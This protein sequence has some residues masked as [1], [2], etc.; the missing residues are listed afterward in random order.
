MNMYKITSTILGGFALAAI[1]GCSS[2][3]TVETKEQ[4]IVMEKSTT[5]QGAAVSFTHNYDGRSEPGFVED[6]Q[7]FIQDEYDSGTLNISMTASEGLNLSS[8]G[9]TSFSMD[10]DAA[11]TINVSVSAQTPGKYYVNLQAKADA[12]NGQAMMR[13]YGIAINVGDPKLYPETKQN[14]TV[15][16]TKDGG[17]IVIMD[18]EETIDK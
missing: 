5:K 18:A 10:G 16:D 12:G 14:V 11:R 8:G 7:V 4:P 1:S 3:S 6:F 9:P 15:E 2:H 13:G 17:K